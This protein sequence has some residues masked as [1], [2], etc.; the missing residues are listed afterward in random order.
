MMK[1]SEAQPRKAHTLATVLNGAGGAGDDVNFGAVATL[2][3]ANRDT[4]TNFV[5]GASNSDTVSITAAT[6]TN[7][8]LTPSGATAAA[9]F[10][11]S[12]V[13]QVATGVTYDVSAIFDA[14]NS[15]VLELGE[16]SSFADLSASTTGSEVVK[17]LASTASAATGITFTESSATA[18]TGFYV[19]AYDAGNAY[20]YY[21]DDDNDDDV[22]AAGEMTLIA[23][24]NDIE[25]GAFTAD[26]FIV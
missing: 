17:G 21:A 5:A 24:F 15:F 26:N 6:V 11:T 23:T 2:L 4:I 8:N 25:T 7:T 1:S 16:M 22:V 12:T 13:A 14:D 9:E 20:L 3:A 10:I 19:V 18:D